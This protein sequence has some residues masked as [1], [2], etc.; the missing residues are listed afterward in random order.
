MT[1]L[2][3]CHDL[4]GHPV[5]IDLIPGSTHVNSIVGNLYTVDPISGDMIV[6]SFK[7]AQPESMKWI[8]KGSM[9]SVHKIENNV[10]ECVPFSPEVEEM[11]AEFFRKKTDSVNAVEISKRKNDII[12]WLKRN[13]VEVKNRGET[14]IIFGSVRV[15]APYT[16][17]D[18]YCDNSIILK[19]VQA[20]IEKCPQ[21]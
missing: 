13:H 5:R 11:M 14:L 17:E 3:E 2:P 18:C 7:N 4:L 1:H 9:R 6:L 20:M 16:S 15:E 10:P 19:R 21:T 8:P 12:K